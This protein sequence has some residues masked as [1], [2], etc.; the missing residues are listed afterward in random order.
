MWWE[1]EPAQ[2]GERAGCEG[3]REPMLEEAGGVWDGEVWEKR[4][5][6]GG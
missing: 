1:Q 2:D 6:S 3:S 4:R 5:R